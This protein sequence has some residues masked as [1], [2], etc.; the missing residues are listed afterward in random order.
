ME[1]S[2]KNLIIFSYDLRINI[3]LAA[4]VNVVLL[5]HF[6]ILNVENEMSIENNFF[7]SSFIFSKI[8]LFIFYL[9]ISFSKYLYCNKSTDTLHVQQII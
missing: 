4:T 6:N 8:K 2:K 1:D 5:K 9:T 7:I 3:E